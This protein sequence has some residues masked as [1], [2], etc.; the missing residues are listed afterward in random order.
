MWAVAIHS[1][2]CVHLELITPVQLTYQWSMLLL[3]VSAAHEPTYGYVAS[4]FVFFADVTY[5]ITAVLRVTS[6]LASCYSTQ[7]S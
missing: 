4:W 5:I 6:Q 1:Y 3:Q 2:N 7:Y